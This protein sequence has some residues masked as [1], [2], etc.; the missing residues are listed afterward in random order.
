MT[1]AV[2]RLPFADQSFDAVVSFETIEHVSEPGLLLQE[3]ARVLTDEGM[4]ICSSP[5]RDFQPFAGKKEPNLFSLEQITINLAR[6]EEK[7]GRLDRA[8]GYLEMARS[9]SPNPAALQQQIDELK[10]KLANPARSDPS[11][12]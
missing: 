4:C 11:A 5:N 12:H 2:G 3:I 6:L 10:K 1:I 8:I 7:E 9:A